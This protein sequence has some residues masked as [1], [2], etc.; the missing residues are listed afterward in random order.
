MKFEAMKRTVCGAAGA[1]GGFFIWLIGGWSGDL[2]ALMVLMGIDLLT[3]L[4]LAGVFGKSRKSKSG[5]VSSKSCWQGLCR[6]GVSLLISIV[7]ATLDRMLELS[8]IRTATI[9]SFILNE[10]ISIT[11]NAGLMGVPIAAPLAKALE[12]L[13]EKEEQGDIPTSS[14][15][16]PQ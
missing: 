14:S 12:L 16:T 4:L 6:K 3:G 9:L 5:A 11:E 1:V 15:G 7:A 10:A 8:Y 2:A 13:R